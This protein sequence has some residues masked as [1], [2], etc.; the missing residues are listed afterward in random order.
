[1]AEPTMLQVLRKFGARGGLADLWRRDIRAQVGGNGSS[2]DLMND[3]AALAQ[4]FQALGSGDLVQPHIRL[5][6]P[7]L[8]PAVSAYTH[9]VRQVRS[10]VSDLEW[11][12]RH[13]SLTRLP[14]RT[15]FQQQCQKLLG[16]SHN[17]GDLIALIFIDIDNFKEI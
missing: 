8:A 14:N 9:S 12:I 10:I 3:A 6:T 2:Q 16:R 7:E 4:A 5:S 17:Q 11:A 15:W 1:M 13:D